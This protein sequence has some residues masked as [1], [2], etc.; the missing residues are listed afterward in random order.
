MGKPKDEGNKADGARKIKREDVA[1]VF[2]R[3]ASLS[4]FL[5]SRG[6]AVGNR[7]HE[8]L[9]VQEVLPMDDMG[10]QRNAG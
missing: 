8:I 4:R 7:R 10:E 1:A 5:G 3:Q 9:H 6:L 2:T